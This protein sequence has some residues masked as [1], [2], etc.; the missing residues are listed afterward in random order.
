M[1]ILLGQTD[2]IHL[3]TNKEEELDQ[4]QCVTS[5]LDLS[6]SP[7]LSFL[8]LSFAFFQFSSTHCFLVFCLSVCQSEF[9]GNMS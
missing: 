1:E 2:P 8:V 6:S 5:I 9:V 7:S 3:Q 4:F